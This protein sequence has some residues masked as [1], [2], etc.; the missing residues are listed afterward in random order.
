MIQTIH[1]KEGG[2]E[3]CNT[4]QCALLSSFL[5]SEIGVT[6]CHFIMSPCCFVNT[7]EQ[8][9]GNKSSEDIQSLFEHRCTPEGVTHWPITSEQRYFIG[10]LSSGR[11]AGSHFLDTK[12]GMGK[13]YFLG[14]FSK[15]CQRYGFIQAEWQSPFLLCSSSGFCVP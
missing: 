2:G 12:K 3:T 4:Q 5:F 8:L 11:H 10:L 13:K 7:T 15:T 9:W 1:N 6:L 14:C